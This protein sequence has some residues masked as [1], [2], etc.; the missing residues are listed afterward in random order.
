MWWVFTIPDVPKNE[1]AV[2]EHDPEALL[3]VITTLQTAIVKASSSEA[4]QEAASVVTV[5]VF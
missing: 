1:R 5:I 4:Q 2:E 3:F